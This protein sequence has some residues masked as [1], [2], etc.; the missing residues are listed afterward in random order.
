MTN[1]T[2]RAYGGEQDLSAMLS[3]IRARPTAHVLDFP[4]LY[5]LHEL[6]GTA[7][8]RE[9]T[10]L[11]LDA[12]SH[13]VGFA[14]VDLAFN[15]MWAEVATDAPGDLM[16]AQI[17][18]WGMERLRQPHEALHNA[19]VLQ[20]SCRAEHT[21]RLAQF[22][23]QGFVQE[24]WHT[25][26]MTRPL[27]EPIPSPQPPPGFTIRHVRGEEEATAVAALHRAAFGT[28]AMTTEHRLAM[29]RVPEGGGGTGRSLG[30][31]RVG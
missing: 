29:M 21:A 6:L 31:L 13:V 22:K 4:S 19:G 28:E 24:D 11:W 20:M 16:F 26:L 1:F 23:Q 8:R 25:V 9:H 3:L 2:A 14:I 7:S 18:V 30:R 27:H 15:T 12:D 5:D 10:Q 17:I